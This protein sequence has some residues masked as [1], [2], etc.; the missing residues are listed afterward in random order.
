MVPETVAGAVPGFSQALV[1]SARQSKRK[2][3]CFPTGPESSKRRAQ[4][5]PGLVASSVSN[6]ADND[7]LRRAAESDM[8]P[9]LRL[10]SV[11]TLLLFSA[12]LLWLD[13]NTSPHCRA[14]I[15]Q[16]RVGILSSGQKLATGAKS[17]ESSFAGVRRAGS[18]WAVRGPS[19]NDAPVKIKSR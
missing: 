12:S 7:S 9:I 3:N 15:S 16:T 17:P 13:V 2:L 18:K 11:G 8:P 19:R 1:K 6:F 14:M 4:S 10:C 5:E